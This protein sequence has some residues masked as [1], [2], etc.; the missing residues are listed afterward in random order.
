MF[1][2]VVGVVSENS[3]VTRVHKFF[4][5]LTVVDIGR[6]GFGIVDEF[7]FCIGIIVFIG[8]ERF[9]AFLTAFGGVRF[10]A[11]RMFSSFNLVVLLAVGGGCKLPIVFDYSKFSKKVWSGKVIIARLDNSTRPVK[12]SGSDK[13]EGSVNGRIDGDRANLFAPESLE[14]GILTVPDLKRIGSNG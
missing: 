9:A 2:V 7:A 1:G 3:I 5:G 12:I 6:G 14:E 13:V 11:F 8:P 4:E 10:E